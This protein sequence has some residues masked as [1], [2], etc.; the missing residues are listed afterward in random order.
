MAKIRIQLGFSEFYPNL[1]PAGDEL[2]FCPNQRRQSAH[3]SVTAG[4]WSA[5][6][7]LS[8][9]T[10]ISGGSTVGRRGGRHDQFN[11]LLIRVDCT[12][13]ARHKDCT[14]GFAVNP[15][16][17]PGGPLTR[18][19]MINILILTGI[20]APLGRLRP[21]RVKQVFDSILLLY[22]SSFFLI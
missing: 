21:R 13:A 18:P 15:I 20:Q 8:Q 3:L 17:S 14:L 6:L 9:E 5:L 2:K 12:P 19:N 4:V 7:N 1:F 11:S 22:S 16:R 10:I